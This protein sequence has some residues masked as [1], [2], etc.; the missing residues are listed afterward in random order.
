MVLSSGEILTIG[1]GIQSQVGGTIPVRNQNKKN[2]EEKPNKIPKSVIRYHKIRKHEKYRVKGEIPQD[3]ISDIK[4]P[5][6]DVDK[7][8][9]LTS[10]Y[11]LVTFKI[12]DESHDYYI[13]SCYQIDYI[14]SPIRYKGEGTK[15][16]KSLLEKSMTDKDTEG[17][18]IVDIKII[19]NET[20]SA[21]FFYKLG[22]RF[23]DKSKNEIIKTWLK[24]E[25][26]ILSPKIT[27]LMYLPKENIQK[28]LMYRMLL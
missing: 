11:K 24:D 6:T 22:F 8:I 25:K 14:S 18:I 12:P 21:G 23:I 15:A 13:K 16:V 7:L 4:V 1:S 19:D 9:Q 27:G 20:S 10:K 26:N 28:L 2:E 3:Y 5:K 17:R